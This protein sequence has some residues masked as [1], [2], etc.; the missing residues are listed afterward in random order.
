[1][2]YI[3]TQLFAVAAASS[4]STLLFLFPKQQQL[5]K[6]FCQGHRLLLLLMLDTNGCYFFKGKLFSDAACRR[7]EADDA[8]P[9]ANNWVIIILS[10]V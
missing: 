5:A 10:V 2:L 3:I 7:V 6:Q 4:A 9:D 1:M 8:A